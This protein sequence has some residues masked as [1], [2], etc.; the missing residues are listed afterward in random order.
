[1]VSSS[2]RR[3]NLAAPPGVTHLLSRKVGQARA[4]TT[5][6]PLP[7]APVPCSSPVAGAAGTKEGE[8]SSPKATCIGQVR[9]QSKQL[10]KAKL[11]KPKP[12][13]ERSKSNSCLMPCRCLHEVLLCSL[14]PPVWKSSTSGSRG[15]R[16]LWWRWARIR[17]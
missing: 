8:P 3:E 13:K 16:S 4:A 14:F 5:L 15:R 11:K 2:P 6:R 9:I 12:E 1:M 7:R 17:F 10:A